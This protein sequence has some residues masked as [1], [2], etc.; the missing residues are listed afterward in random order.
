[1]TE[2]TDNYGGDSPSRL[3]R[4][5]ALLLQ[6]TER[7]GQITERL[8][9]IAESNELAIGR[10]NRIETLQERTQQQVDSNARAI[11]AWGGRIEES[12]VDTEEIATA[13]RADL[14]ERIQTAQQEWNQRF[15]ELAGQIRTILQRLSGNGGG[16]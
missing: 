13:T 5:E 4:I 10:L 12:I 3:D 14:A 7:L 16:L 15:E 11:Q 2:A 8:D 9:R 1:M 6:T